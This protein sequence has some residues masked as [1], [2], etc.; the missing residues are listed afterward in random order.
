MMTHSQRKGVWIVALIA[1]NAV[2]W[3]GIALLV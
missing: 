2:V 3:I 1:V